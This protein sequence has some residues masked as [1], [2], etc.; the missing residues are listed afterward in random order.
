MIKDLACLDKVGKKC[1]SRS[2]RLRF[3]LHYTQHARA[4]A[5]DRRRIGKIVNFFNGRD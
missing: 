4:T 5:G 2:Q 1:L 3:Y